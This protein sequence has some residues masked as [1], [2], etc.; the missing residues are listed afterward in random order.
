M[1]SLYN[2]LGYWASARLEAPCVIEA[3]TGRALSYR[4][5]LAAVQAMYR[6]LGP[7][8]SNLYLVLP[9]GIAN[10]V[11]WLSALTGGHTLVPLAP[12]ATTREWNHPT[13]LF[14]PDVVFAD[15]PTPLTHER[16]LHL[17]G[18]SVLHDQCKELLTRA[19]HRAAPLPLCEGRACSSLRE[20]S[21]YGLLAEAQ[22]PAGVR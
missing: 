3:E 8:P 10:A 11:I 16:Y 19:D 9:G 12:E 20:H 17:D 1:R 13:N 22:R 4:Q 15:L 2:H 7:R 6:Y 14:S 5:C 18:C 21:R